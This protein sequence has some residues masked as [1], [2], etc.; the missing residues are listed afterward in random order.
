MRISR[1]KF[2]TIILIALIGVIILLAAIYHHTALWKPEQ[3]LITLLPEAPICYLTLKDLGSLVKTFTRSEF[4]KQVA[5][6]PLLAEIQE[7][8]WWKELAYQKALWE[9]EMGG[10]LDL[11]TV[12]A[13]FGE[14]TILA[15]YEQD[16]EL[17]FLLISVVGGAEKL[18]IEALTAT[19]AINPQYQRI[20]TEHNGLTVNTIIG[21]PRDFS[22]AFIGKVGVLSLSYPLL[23]ETLDIYV[24]KKMGFLARHPMQGN[25]ESDKSTGYVDVPRLA[26]ALKETVPQLRSIVELSASLLGDATPWSFGNRYADGVVISRH[27]IRHRD[28]EVSPTGRLHRDR[29]VSPTEDKR[30]RGVAPKEGMHRDRE[31]SPTGLPERTAFVSVLPT[32]RQMRELLPNSGLAQHL[33][34]GFI[35]PKPEEVSVVPSIVLLMKGSELETD[36]ERLKAR[37]ISIAGKPLAFLAPQDY[38]GSVI[39]PFQLRFNFLLALTGGYAIVNDTLVFSTTLPGLKSVIDT[40]SGNAPALEFGE[41]QM[42]IEPSLFVP[43]VKRFLPLVTLLTSGQLVDAGLIEQVNENLFPLASLGPVSVKIVERAEATAAEIRVVLEK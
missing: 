24:G 11:A 31:V 32:P 19:D 22:Y 9:H 29:E 39:Q 40:V 8:R 1:K 43:E 27:F 12:K 17:S 21:Y 20:Q 36:L 13:Y 18:S 26:A 5:E 2:I 14:E 10:K 23:T 30:D 41:V 7:Q 42:F 3:S 16:D 28:R 33:T 37:E 25:Y 34:V 4:G 38:R 6:M 15:L 35:A